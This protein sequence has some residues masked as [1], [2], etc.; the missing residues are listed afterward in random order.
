MDVSEDIVNYNPS[1]V[2]GCLWLSIQA[3]LSQVL[4]QEGQ[5][6]PLPGLPQKV[7]GV[8]KNSLEEQDKDHPLI[9]S[10]S[11]LISLFCNLYKVRVISLRLVVAI[12]VSGKSN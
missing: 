2:L 4:Q 6:A 7:W 12:S 10:M 5:L 3:V 1:S 11:D 8:A 9:P